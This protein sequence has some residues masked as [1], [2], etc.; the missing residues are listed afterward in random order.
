MNGGGKKG[1]KQNENE[2]KKKVHRSIQVTGL[3]IYRVSYGNEPVFELSI[4]ENRQIDSYF[5][6][7]AIHIFPAVARK[8]FFFLL[9]KITC[10]KVKSGK[11][12]IHE[13]F[14]K[15]HRLRFVQSSMN[16]DYDNLYGI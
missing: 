13:I 6:S 5:L 10:N 15:K 3:E 7:F 16:M 4:R 2:K 11:K 9:K 12:N 1:C 8:S 14:I